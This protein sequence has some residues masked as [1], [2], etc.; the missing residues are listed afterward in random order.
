[1]R[2]DDGGLIDETLYLVEDQ[3]LRGV[4]LF[5]PCGRSVGRLEG[6]VLH[7]HT[8]AVSYLVVSRPRMLGLR[9]ERS[10]VPRSA[11]VAVRPGG[12]FIVQLPDEPDAVRAP[13]PG[14]NPLLR[15]DPAR[16]E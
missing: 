10:V 16:P 8:G 1:M 7:K 6:V 4:R 2:G 9:R 14:T 15:L 13:T 12:G 3:S 5:A 11:L